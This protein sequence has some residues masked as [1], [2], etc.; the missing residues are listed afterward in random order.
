MTEHRK[1]NVANIVGSH[2][3]TPTDCRQCLRTEQER[4]G[5]SWTGTIMNKRMRTSTPNNIHRVVLYARL[6]SRSHHFESTADYG[7]RIRQGPKINLVQSLGIKSSIPSSNDFAFVVF[8]RIA[9]NNLELKP[10]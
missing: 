5:S 1:R 4:D 2:K 8:R 6:H 9:Q 7:I 3:L 10:V